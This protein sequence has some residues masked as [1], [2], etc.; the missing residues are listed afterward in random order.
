MVRAVV[1]FVVKVFLLAA[2]AAV[3]CARLVPTDFRPTDHPCFVEASQSGLHVFSWVVKAV[4]EGVVPVRVVDHHGVLERTLIPSV[5]ECDVPF[6][7]VGLAGNCLL[8]LS[9]LE[10]DII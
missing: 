7:L 10:T 5:H 2:V 6:G 4:L 8:R 9:N 1:V 3:F